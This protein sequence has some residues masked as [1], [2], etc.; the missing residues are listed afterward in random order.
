MERTIQ[1]ESLDNGKKNHQQ[2]LIQTMFTSLQRKNTCLRTFTKQAYSWN[3]K[4]SC[5]FTVL[6]CFI[7]SGMPAPRMEA[8]HPHKTFL[9]GAEVPTQNLFE[10]TE[11]SV[12][13]PISVTHSP[14]S[15]RV[16]QSVLQASRM[17]LK[18]CHCVNT[19]GVPKGTLTVQINDAHG[20]K[21]WMLADTKKNIR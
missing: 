21:R 19:S 4:K 20:K 17:S 1:F 11:G 6:E 9:Q 18:E 13:R 5:P 14:P 3:L 16:T 7:F 2:S 12:S 10:K 15:N 8:A